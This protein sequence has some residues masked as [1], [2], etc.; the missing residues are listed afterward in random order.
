MNDERREK[1]VLLRVR[2]GSRIWKLLEENQNRKYSDV[3]TS[4]LED[5][6]D[7]LEGIK[8]VPNRTITLQGDTITLK[9]ISKD[10][11]QIKKLLEPVETYFI[12][13]VVKQNKEN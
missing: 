2:E 11:E 4:A 7:I 9:K 3:V 13:E 10:M 12:K 6:L 8:T 1:Q 5:Y